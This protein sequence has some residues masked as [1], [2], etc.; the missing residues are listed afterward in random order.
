MVTI[1]LVVALF[2]MAAVPVASIAQVTPGN[3]DY[4][5]SDEIVPYDPAD[6]VA[7]FTATISIAEDPGTPGYP[8]P[9]VGF[10][11]GLANDAVM[12]AT[13]IVAADALAGLN[14]GDGPDFFSPNINP[15]NG[16]GFT[17]AAVY[18]LIGGL[19]LEFPDPTPV[20]L[21][22]YSADAGVLMGDPD[23]LD[24]E[25]T[26]TN[27]LGTPP[28]E[29]VVVVGAT[30]MPTIFNNGTISFIPDNVDFTRGDADADGSF[31]GL[32]DALFILF[33]QF[34]GGPEPP[35]FDSAD[36]DDDGVVNGLVD[37]LFVLAF[38]FS[39][40]DPPPPPPPG[41]PCGSD[42]T[43]DNLGCDSYGVCP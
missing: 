6:G 17:F 2:C 19:F 11:M 25:L 42:P 22:E 38:Q 20:I 12:T 7:E 21:V 31:N 27:S 13:D 35:C 15:T 26:W 8:N 14:D 43:A 24:A 36:A 18:S 39:G 1:R 37:A 4:I 30:S 16:P 29:N 40:G 9:T 28:V 33:Y 23:G 10:A 3:F 41:G 5:A 34:D 32:V